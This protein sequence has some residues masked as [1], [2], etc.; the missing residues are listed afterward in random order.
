MIESLVSVRLPADEELTIKKNRLTG[1]GCE[2]GK[3]IAVVTG[4]HGD[5][6]EGQYVCYELVRL[7]TANMAHLK[8]TVDIYPSINPL[9]MESVSRAVPMSG[10]DMN[11]VFP[12]STSGAVAE[13]IAA[14]LVEDIK[15]ADVCVDIHANN[16][17]I[18]E[19]P[20]VRISSAESSHLLKYAKMLNTD[21]VWVHDSNAVGEGSLAAALREVGVPTLVIEMGVGQRITKAYCKQLLSGIFNLMSK[22][23]IWVGPTENVSHPM[24]SSDGAVHV[25]HSGESGIFIPKVEHNMWVQKGTLIGEIVTPITGTVEEEITAPSDGLIFSLREYPIVYEGSVIARIL[26]MS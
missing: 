2:D 23:G 25:I 26:S 13:N 5:E 16:I 21:F 4:I 11:R 15:G 10:L 22:L 24:V 19:I 14:K 9:G 6:L 7:I 20:Q 3:R 8:G 18:R 12:G 17:F 1:V